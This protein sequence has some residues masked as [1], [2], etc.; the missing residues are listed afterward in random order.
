MADLVRF[1][2]EIDH[3]ITRNFHFDYIVLD[4]LFLAAYIVLLI[5]RK[6]YGP[7]KAG[8]VFGVIMYVIDGVIWTAMGIREYR[9]SAPWIKHVTDFMMDVSYG[10]VAFSW[11][12]IAF[13]KKSP[14]D[15]ALWTLVL[16]GGWL[17]VP[18][19]SILVHLN[20]DPITTV[21][22]MQSQVWLQIVVVIAGYVL[23]AAMRYSYR[24][25]LYVFAIGCMLSF[26]MEFSLFVS[27][28]RPRNLQVLVYETLILTNQGVPYVYVIWDRILPAL[29]GRMGLL[30]RVSA[31]N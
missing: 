30:R 2:R 25:I 15:V 27:G 26:M 5:R 17:L 11:V 20:D 1:L 24:T 31:G 6:R 18:F 12:W 28:I 29:A 16:F 10:I 4:A 22:Y 7:L 21:R 9:I 23:L 8:L 13:E 14:R 19:A 3:D